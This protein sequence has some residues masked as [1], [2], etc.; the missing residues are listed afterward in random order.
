MKKY[1]FTESQMKSI[2]DNLIQ[3]ETQLNEQS[4]MHDK[5]VAVQK[6]LNERLKLNL[7]TDGK[8]G[9]NSKTYSAI[10]KYQSM[11]GLYPTDGT[12]GPNTEEKMPDSDKKMFS[13]YWSDSIWSHIFGS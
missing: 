8:T 1:I 9:P 3:E 12:W 13:K 7:V 6:F 5:I 11:I 10:Q 2:L 4:E